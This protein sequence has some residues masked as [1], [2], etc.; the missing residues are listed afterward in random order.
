MRTHLYSLALHAAA[1]LV[2]GLRPHDHVVDTQG[3]ALAADQATSRLQIVP[4]GAQSGGRPC[5]V[6]PDWYADCSHRCPIAVYSPSCVRRRLYR[7]H[8]GPV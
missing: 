3:A 1:R 5:A 4:P 6:L 2:N 8:A 7:P